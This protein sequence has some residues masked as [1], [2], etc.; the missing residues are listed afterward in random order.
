MGAD[1]SSRRCAGER[2]SGDTRGSWRA[3]S[4]TG[5]H[6]GKENTKETNETRVSLARKLRQTLLVFPS[7]SSLRPGRP[8]PRGYTS[9]MLLLLLVVVL[10]LLVVW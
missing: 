9:S 3:A 4:K 6:D 1:E 10:L 2:E 5:F 8:R 7:C